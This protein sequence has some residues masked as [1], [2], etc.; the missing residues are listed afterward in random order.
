M[1]SN[2][3]TLLCS[4]IFVSLFALSS[5][6]AAGGYDYRDGSYF[7]GGYYGD[8]YY[9][10]GHRYSYPHPVWY[11]SGC[12]YRDRGYVGYPYYR[13]PYHPY[14]YGQPYYRCGQVRIADGRGGWVWGAGT[15]CY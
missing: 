11:S 4:T 1:R 14:Y 10:Y 2:V 7:G 12:C 6:A 13:R 3:V 5:P 9:E 15:V 8:R